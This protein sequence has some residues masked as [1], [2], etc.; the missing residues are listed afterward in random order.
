[1]NLRLVGRWKDLLMATCLQPMCTCHLVGSPWLL[2]GLR[3]PQDHGC[4]T[5]SVIRKIL[6]RDCTSFGL[7]QFVRVATR[8][9]GEWQQLL[10]ALQEIL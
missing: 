5:L 8:P 9:M 2:N 10:L 1:M 4:C 7:S 3:P 6:V